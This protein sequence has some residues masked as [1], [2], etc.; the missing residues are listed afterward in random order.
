MCTHP[1]IRGVLC[2]I[3]HLVSS[4]FVSSAVWLN[5]L[6]VIVF[7]SLRLYKHNSTA[8]IVEYFTLDFEA[9]PSSLPAG[10]HGRHGQIVCPLEQS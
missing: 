5:I 2:H 8:S 3:W 7:K 1:F 6:V 9:V 4:Q 10:W